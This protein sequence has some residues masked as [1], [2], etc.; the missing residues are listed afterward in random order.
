MTMLNNSATQD[1]SERLMDAIQKTKIRSGVDVESSSETVIKFEMSDD[2]IDFSFSPAQRPSPTHWLWG[3]WILLTT[4][5]MA[6][7]ATGNLLIGNLSALGLASIN[8]YCTGALL[9]S[10]AYFYYHGEW[11]KINSIDAEASGM[12]KVL[13]RT[14][15]NRFDWLAII[16]CMVSGLF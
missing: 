14:W 2:G 10:I 9:F 6:S 15:D 13:T 11:S 12:T 5:S 4:L 3:N 16:F 1:G 8:Y 7:F